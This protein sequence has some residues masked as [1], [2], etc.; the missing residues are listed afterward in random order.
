MFWIFVVTGGLAP[1]YKKNRK[2]ELFRWWRWPS[3]FLLCNMRFAS[4]TELTFQKRQTSSY[5][6][7]NGLSEVYRLLTTISFL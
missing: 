4:R 3:R 7:L 6:S 5:L 2:Y 1:H